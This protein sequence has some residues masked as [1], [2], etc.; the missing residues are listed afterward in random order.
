MNIFIIKHLESKYIFAIL[1]LLVVILY[2]RYVQKYGL[3]LPMWDD[4]DSGLDF[5][6]QWKQAVSPITNK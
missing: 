1:S 4:Y 6:L 3:N 2:L 5:L